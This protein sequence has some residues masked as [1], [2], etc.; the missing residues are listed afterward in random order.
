MAINKPKSVEAYLYWLNQE[1]DVNID[2]NVER[3]Y[4]LVL[5]QLTIEVNNSI[6]WQSLLN[7]LKEY[8]DEYLIITKNYNLFI[9]SDYKPILLKKSYSSLIEKTFRINILNNN[10]FPQEPNQNG[11]VLP[12]NWFERINDIIRTTIEVKYL[13]GV[14]FVANKI[15]ALCES[16]NLECEISYEA[17]EE[18]YYASHVIIKQEYTILD[19][20][21]NEVSVKIP[22]EI[23]IT[24]QLQEIIKKLLHIH[25]EKRR[26][27]N[28]QEGIVDRVW[29][30]DYKCDEFATNY[31]G[32]ILHYIEGMILDV[33]DKLNKSREEDNEN[34]I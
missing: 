21:Y 5:D 8:N 11:W 3:H 20:K 31:L 7:D 1:L 9:G 24:T 15:K 32:H 23:Q 25:Y 34:N 28:N 4:E 13:D 2:I 14:E 19:S 12:E 29:Q 10:N 16:Q 17:S 6:F 27:E 18:G 26:I 33:R 30:W 22:I